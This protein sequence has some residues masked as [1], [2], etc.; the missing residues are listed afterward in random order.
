M[1]LWSLMQPVSAVLVA[2]KMMSLS[3]EANQPTDIA[4]TDDGRAYLL[5]GVNGRVLVFNS[6][7][8]LDFIIKPDGEMVLNLPMGIT[9]AGKRLY[10]ADSGN[11]RIAIFDLNGVFQRD[12]PLTARQPPEPVSILFEDDRLFWSDRRNHQIC[13]TDLKRNDRTHCWGKQGREKGA[14]DYPF[15]LALDEQG[16][17]H[18]VDVLNARVQQ[19]DRAGSF[20]F[21]FGGLGLAE[22]QLYRPNGLALSSSGPLLVS[23]AYLG[24]VSLF[25][26]GR[27]LGLL[28]NRAGEPLR[29]DVPV[30][31]TVWQDRLYVVDAAKQRVDV[32]RLMASGRET[33]KKG[34]AVTE[35][36]S[37]TS[38]HLSWAKG[39]QSSDRG[40]KRIPPVA[41]LEMCYSCHHGVVV[42]SRRDIGQGEQHPDIHYP[43]ENQAVERKDKLPGSFPLV[44]DELYCGS[45]HTPHNVEV[46]QA[47]LDFNPWLRVL[48]RDGD[49]C[50]RCHESRLDSTLDSKQPPSGTN[51]PIGI[52]LKQPPSEMAAGYATAEAL[53]QGLPKEL[54]GQGVKLGSRQQLICQSCHQVHGAERE[55]LLPIDNRESQ[56]CESCHQRHTAKDLDEARLKGIHPVNIELEKPV[57]VGDV[58]VKQIT[59]LTCHTAHDAVQGSPLLRFDHRNG[60]L[61]SFCHDGFEAVAKSDHNLS[62]TA[63]QSKN[64]FG[65]KPEQSGLC[66]SCHTLHRGNAVLPSLFADRYIPYP[67]EA[68]TTR[69]DLLCLSCH[70]KE[71]AAEGAVVDNFTHPAESLILRSKPEVMPLLLHDGTISEFG[72]IACITCHDPHRW[73]SKSVSLPPPTGNVEGDVS[74]SFLRHQDLKGTFCI[75]CHGMES[76]LKYKYYH[77]ELARDIGVDYLK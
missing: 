59:C 26:N 15:Q 21:Q 61:C 40:L 44:A 63:K 75:D 53:W 34:R 47:K 3:S 2:E 13:Q 18:V 27:F 20:S 54:A 56:L 38:C 10:I 60:K 37:C 55:A 31:L 73:R 49:L 17:L 16:Y 68:H 64:R 12:I 66:G 39:Y 29:F 65:E 28:Q 4:V 33:A 45:C 1:L 36:R 76:R 8:R 35:E 67:G 50:Q 9:I 69:R 77:D 48:D 41:S 72:E 24:T 42:D 43:L 11:H 32:F 7:G 62:I 57:K 46:E 74:N 30:G 25:Q 6:T 58:E 70:R 14:F 51:H 5:D 19:F 22:G 71:G 52:Y 23:D